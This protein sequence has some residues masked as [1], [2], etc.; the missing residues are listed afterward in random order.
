MIKPILTAA[1]PRHGSP[2]S[3]SSAIERIA[4]SRACQIAS[5]R[6]D[7]ETVDPRRV[8][9]PVEALTASHTTSGAG[10]RGQARGPPSAD[11]ACRTRH[12]SHRQADGRAPRRGS[13]EPEPLRRAGSLNSRRAVQ[14]TRCRR[15]RRLERSS[16]AWHAS[17][18]TAIVG[19]RA[20][21]SSTAM[22]RWCSAG[23][24]RNLVSQGHAIARR[25]GSAGA[26]GGWLP[27]HRPTGVGNRARQAA[28]ESLAKSSPLDMRS[29]WKHAVA[30]L[31]AAAR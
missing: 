20:G 7:R 9:K 23:R 29:T 13:A 11:Y 21:G 2:T 1:I 12:R 22:E 5:T 4:R 3:K 30:R 17:G 10:R 28:G 8:A 18:A 6:R 25:P 19:S 31:T 14:Q 26:A 15:C 16:P 24:G 27:V